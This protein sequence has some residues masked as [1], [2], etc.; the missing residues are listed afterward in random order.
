MVLET[1][2]APPAHALAPVNPVTVKVG[3]H[4][5]NS[6]FLV[7]VEHDVTLRNS[8]S[9][10]TMAMGGDLRIRNQQSYQIAGNASGSSTFT[11]EGDDQPTKL[12]VGG[13]I[14]WDSNNAIVYVQQGFT[15][16]ADTATYTAHERDENN[17]L[18]QLPAHAPTAALTAASPFIDGRTQQSPA[19]IAHQPSKSLI[20]VAACVRRLPHPDPSARRLPGH[21][22]AGHRPGGAADQPVPE[23]RARAALAHARDDQRPD[24][25]HR[26][27]GEPVGDHLSQPAR[28]PRRRC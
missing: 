23:R 21:R 16:V 19:S 9:Q 28:P 27:P 2:T 10:G 1:A 13:G 5:A 26:R 22:A 11:D 7:F 3:G 17:A 18:R 4:R 24:D 20:N 12:F 8:E 15:K 14:Q 6:G 25:D